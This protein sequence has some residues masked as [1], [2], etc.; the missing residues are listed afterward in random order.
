MS[1]HEHLADV[2]LG[3]RLVSADGHRQAGEFT[4][5]DV[6]L[7]G[8]HA[9]P[10]IEAKRGETSVPDRTGTANSACRA[11]ES[12]REEP[13]AGGIHWSRRGSE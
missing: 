1:G 13:I 10:D 6:A 7:S 4:V 8:V 2:R 5:D 12:G 3:W 9:D 11:V